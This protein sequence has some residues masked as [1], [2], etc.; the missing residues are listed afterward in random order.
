MGEGGIMNVQVN[1]R[2]YGMTK[3]TLVDQDGNVKDYREFKNILLN[4]FADRFF[5]GNTNLF[6]VSDSFDH[7][8]RCKAGTANSATALELTDI[9]GTSLGTCSR[10][11]VTNTWS[12]TNPSH[13][14]L[15]SVNK[16]YFVTGVAT[17]D[18]GE[19]LLYSSDDSLG[20]ARQIFDPVISKT[21][22][23]Q[24]VVE[25]TIELTVNTASGTVVAAN[26]DGSDVAWKFF[27]NLNHVQN[28]VGVSSSAYIG[29]PFY[30]TN[31]YITTGTSNNDSNLSTDYA[32]TIKGTAIL[33]YSTAFTKTLGSYTSGQGYRD[34]TMLIDTPYS[35]GSIGELV[36]ASANSSRAFCRLTFTPALIKTDE[37]KL[38]LTVR[39]GLTLN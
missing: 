29:N 27:M 2:A 26:F 12:V 28:I 3:V 39:F 33:N 11:S 20:T 14:T 21:E 22:T 25:W 30:G 38:T 31:R 36:L 10:Y 24:L 34:F 1:S 15:T 9:V 37:Y 7:V 17:G 18:I 16:F 4:K 32:S 13:V 8:S 35:N 5:N 19:I 6:S 23:D